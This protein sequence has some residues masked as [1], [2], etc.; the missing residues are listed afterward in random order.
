[1][2]R[3]REPSMDDPSRVLLVTHHLSIGGA[4]KQA[5]ELALDLRKIGLEI[6]VLLLETFRGKVLMPALESDLLAHGIRF[7]HPFNLGN[8]ILNSVRRRANRRGVNPKS[9]RSL[10]TETPR[11]KRERFWMRLFRKVLEQS[12]S[13]FL[14]QNESPVERKAFSRL[15]SARPSLLADYL[16]VVR[17]LKSCDYS[18][19]VSFLRQPN[20][21][22]TL[23]CSKLGRDALPCERNDSQVETR[24]DDRIKELRLISARARLITSNTE[25]SS[26]FLQ[27]MLPKTRVSWLPNKFPTK[28]KPKANGTGDDLCVVA[29][30]EPQKA[31]REVLREMELLQA[32]HPQLRLHIFGDGPEKPNLEEFVNQRGMNSVIFHGEQLSPWEI[33]KTLGCGFLIVNSTKEGSS[34]TLHEG[35]SQGLIPIVRNSVAEFGQIVDSGWADFVTTNGNDGEIADR[36]SFLISDKEMRRK[37]AMRVQKNFE[38]YWKRG[39]QVRRDFLVK[40][41]AR[42]ES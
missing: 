9:S 24:S 14:F 27:E 36:I 38:N 40:E 2:L 30:L 33:V 13:L 11:V 32:W 29:R 4:E 31:I 18:K 22:A 12:I 1:M 37:V 5:I 16:L 34:N 19:V 3:K 21:V 6:D 41:F 26:K 42:S 35:V 7:V 8:W 10:S 17:A 23:A 25:N 28:V 20:L 39:A 15:F